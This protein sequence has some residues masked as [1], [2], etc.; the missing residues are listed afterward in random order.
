MP[1]F[2][3]RLAPW[4][5][6]YNEAIGKDAA[7]EVAGLVGV[8]ADHGVALGSVLDVACGTGRHLVHL[9]EHATE[10][11]GSDVSASMIAVAADRLPEVP[12]H[13]AD[14]RELALGRTFDVVTCLFSSIGHVADADDLDR[15]IAA[16]AD[17]VAPGGAL[18][19]EP[20][21]TPEVLVED[22]MRDAA[23]V[24]V[25]DAAVSRT[26]RSWVEDGAVV[27]DWVWA[28]ATR[29]DIETYRERLRMPVFTRQRYL[30]T[31][32]AAGLAATWVE[33]DTF[34]RGLVLGRRGRR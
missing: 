9:R 3:E 24:S 29:D 28:L 27:M 13:E 32:E 14:F 20:W 33:H 31:V 18:V 5:D 34:P 12:L 6:A 26:S 17:H 7:R 25:G 1:I 2:Y 10:V 15:A 30:D 21:L 11:A 22:G 16:M 4:Y 8:L 23:G 19:V